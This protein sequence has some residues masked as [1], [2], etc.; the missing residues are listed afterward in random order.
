[1]STSRFRITGARSHVTS[2]DLG[3]TTFELHDLAP[4]QPAKPKP[5]CIAR[6]R[7]PPRGSFEWDLA[8]EGYNE[9]WATLTV[10]QQWLRDECNKNCIELRKHKEETNSS[11]NERTWITKTTYVCARKGTGGTKR[12]ERKTDREFKIASKRLEDGC[13]CRLTVKTY[14]GT[15]EILGLYRVEHTHPIGDLNV[16]YTR[17]TPEVRMRMME[18]LRMRIGADHIL[19]SI[20]NDPTSTRRDSF[21]SM[22]DVRRIQRCLDMHMTRLR[23]DDGPSTAEWVKILERQ[24]D[25]LLF[26]L[27]VRDRWGHGIPVAFMIS[28][29]ATGNTIG[30]FL[31]LVKH[32]SLEVVPK[33]FMTDRDLAQINAIKKH[34]P[35]AEVFLCWWHV[36][37]AWQQ[38]FHVTQFADLWTKLKKWVR[39]GTVAEYDQIWREIQ[40]EA[41]KSVVDYLATEWVPV[42]K[43]WS[44]VYRK[45]RH[46]FEESDTNM[47]VESYHRKRRQDIGFEGMDLAKK[48]EKDI[49][50]LGVQ[51]SEDQIERLGIHSF[52]VRSQS[53]PDTVYNIDIDAYVCDCPA[54]P[55]LDIC[56]HLVAVQTHFPDTAAMGASADHFGN[57]TDGPGEAQEAPVNRMTAAVTTTPEATNQ[58]ASRQVNDLLVLTQHIFA[59]VKDSPDMQIAENIALINKALQEIIQE[60]S[61]SKKAILPPAVPVPPNQHSWPETAAKMIGQ[62][63][64]KK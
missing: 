23:S 5:V 20:Q 32:K 51:I 57:L 22:A 35:D 33:H 38:H 7:G 42:S 47:L 62:A 8:K 61:S 37:H 64:G 3:I 28:S 34:F 14:P 30:F 39:V 6:P 48:A 24:G 2:E 19:Q 56:K 13:T 4:A 60:I 1:M 27:L 40:A 26:T 59:Q 12:Y 43:Q 21:V 16:I 10:F 54:Y 44:A 50:R 45:G 9:R 46:V 25:L 31:E 41:P 11:T 58:D 52:R 15:D 49:F 63:K 29:N 53:S 18:M 36:L 55:R 17:V